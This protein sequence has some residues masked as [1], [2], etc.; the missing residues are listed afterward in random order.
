[1]A[2]SFAPAGN[3]ISPG[4]FI[5]LFGSGLAKS[6]MTATAAPFPPSLNGVTVLINGKAA[7]IYFVSASQINCLV[8]YS[9][10]GPTAT[11]M[12]QNGTNSNTVTVPVAATSPGIYSLD[13]SGTGPGAVEH[14]DG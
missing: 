6:S 2:A 9:V 14:L 13:Q 4:Q 10:T 7:P 12:V 11:I 3:P 1:S 8:P 5:A